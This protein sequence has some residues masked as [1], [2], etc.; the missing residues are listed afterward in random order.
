MIAIRRTELVSVSEP[1]LIFYDDL[2]T[3]LR[4]SLSG[5]NRDRLLRGNVGAFSVLVSD[6]VL[7]IVLYDLQT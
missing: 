3:E 2:S 5:H 6:D 1:E 7:S 4:E